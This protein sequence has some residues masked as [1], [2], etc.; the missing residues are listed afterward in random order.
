MD[1]VSG[2]RCTRQGLLILDS[3]TLFF[4]NA[5]FRWYYR[6]LTDG[7]DFAAE[8][9]FAKALISE[10]AANLELSWHGNSRPEEAVGLTAACKQLCNN[11]ELPGIMIGSISRKIQ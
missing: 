4:R 2:T 6:V 7:F 8:K 5:H 1:C 3:N 11:E 9:E 10:T